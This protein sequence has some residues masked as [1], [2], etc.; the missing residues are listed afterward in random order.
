MN[1]VRILVAAGL[2]VGMAATA[3]SAQ[4]L[5]A[6]SSTLSYQ[7]TYGGGEDSFNSSDT[8]SVSDLVMDDD[9]SLNYHQAAGGRV[10][11]NPDRPWG[12]EVSVN[13]RHRFSIAGGLS[14]FSRIVAG[15][16]VHVWASALGEGIATMSALPQG[17]S[18]EFRFTMQEELAARLTGAV[19]LDPDG[20]NLMAWVALQ[21]FDGILW[22]TVFDSLL[23]PTQEG[24]F[25]ID[26]SLVP[27]DYRLVGQS[28]GDAYAGVRPEH[29]N[30]WVYDL[31]IALPCLADFNRDGGVDGSDVVDFFR[32]WSAG[33]ST[34]DVNEDGGVDGSDVVTFFAAWEGGC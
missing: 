12:T 10:L 23:M 22:A 3:A 34:A 28:N 25:D 14:R 18:L 11:D 20:Q 17:S 15:G 8:L 4:T 16:R 26:L 27:G 1:R 6:R 29:L 9:R 7:T 5:T 13:A 31:Q 19:S 32:S 33:D 21:R 2:L 30:T 24:V